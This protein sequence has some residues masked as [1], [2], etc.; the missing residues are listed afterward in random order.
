MGFTKGDPPRDSRPRANPDHDAQC[1]SSVWELIEA[2]GRIAIRDIFC[3]TQI[4]YYDIK[5][6]RPCSGRI[7]AGGEDRLQ[8]GRRLCP[9]L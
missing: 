8:C 4:G 5:K 9:C 7:T 2:R 6:N 3:N 1:I